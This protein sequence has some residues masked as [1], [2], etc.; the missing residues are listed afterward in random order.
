MLDKSISQEVLDKIKNVKPKPR[1][2]FLL[3]NYAI[4]SLGLISLILGSLAFATI[5]YM[6]IN[7][8]WDVHQQ[9]AGT[10]PKFI[11]LTLPYFWLI[12]LSLFILAAYVNFKHTKKGYK[13]PLSKVILSSVV[14]NI[15]FGLLLYGTGVAR[16]VDDLLAVRAPFY[17]QLINPRHQLWSNIED[18][19]LAGMVIAIEDE[20]LVID[21]VNHNTWYVNN[22]RES[23]PPILPPGFII[24]EGTI[25]RIIGRPM[26]DGY[27]MAEKILPMRGMHWIESRPPMPPNMMDIHERKVK[28]MRIIR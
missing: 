4:W 17:K 8:D 3:K 18:G 22:F 9:I 2:E 19:F 25:L 1:W 11:L 15:L 23:L 24:E 10:M 20:F 27:F 28:G 7:N 12:F 5:L 21:D 14:I 6:M 26:D 13:F 16:A